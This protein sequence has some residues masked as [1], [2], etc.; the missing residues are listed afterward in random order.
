[1]IRIVFFQPAAGRTMKGQMLVARGYYPGSS[2]ASLRKQKHFS[3]SFFSRV[4]NNLPP[5]FI[6]I[7]NNCRNNNCPR[8]PYDF[9]FFNTVFSEFYCI[10][11]FHLVFV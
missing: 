7:R 11:V 8:L 4:C 10:V 1:M 6:T 5:A 2:L 9:F 3:R